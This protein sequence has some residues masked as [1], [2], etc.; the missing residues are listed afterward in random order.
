[1][2]VLLLTGP[3]GVGKTTT[4]NRLSTQL[5]E[6]NQ[7]HA[8]VEVEALARV[9]PWPDDE[10]AFAHLSLLVRSYR[11]RGYPLLLVGATIDGDGYLAR[12]MHA[13]DGSEV[14]PARLE[15]ST[16]TLTSR[17]REREPADWS[18]LPRLLDA[19]ARLALESATQAGEALVLNTETADVS[20][21]A[22]QLRH[23]L[24]EP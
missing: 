15:A 4:L 13:L 22:N 11:E 24:S 16:S 20:A 9:H 2:R 17:V 10:A 18:G 19:C 5:A 6:A 7:H 14:I 3:P 12:T 1:V 23:A 21:I 8:V